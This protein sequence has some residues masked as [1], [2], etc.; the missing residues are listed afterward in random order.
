MDLRT[1]Y[2]GLELKHPIVASASPLSEHLDNIKRMEDA[3]A[4][5][6]VMFSL[7]EE[8][9]R[10]ENA[11]MEHF[12]RTGANSFAE[13]LSY[14][15]DVFDYPAGPDSYLELVRRAAEAT[16]IPIIGSLNGATS[17]GWADMARQMQ[18]AGARGIELNVYYIPANLN[19]TGR[20]VEQGYTDVVKSVKSAVSVPVALKLSSFFSSIGHMARE[21]DQ[22]GADALV[23]FNRFYQPDFDLDHMQVKPNLSLSS[24][25]EIRLPLLWIAILYGRIDASLGATRGVHSPAEVFKYILAGADAVMTT[26]ALLKNGIGFL[27][28]LVEGLEQMMSEKGYESVE[29]ARGSMS[30]L[31]VADPGAYE[32]ANYIKVLESYENEYTG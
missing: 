4:A 19:L 17:E 15:P 13:S 3:G 7:F 5:A 26:S 29:Q 21:L 11:A 22:A 8:Q 14:F 27:G 28:E 24:P 2:M 30:Q 12:M 9:I 16:D 25:G 18:E 1:T 31:N 20:E 6:V 32:R 10:H 23:L